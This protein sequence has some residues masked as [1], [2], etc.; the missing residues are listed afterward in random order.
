MAFVPGSDNVSQ[1]LYVNILAAELSEHIDGVW[2]YA[3]LSDSPI[4][5]TKSRKLQYGD[6]DRHHRL[7]AAANIVLHVTVLDCHPMV[8]LEANA[9]GRLSL[10]MNYKLG[11]LEDHAAEQLQS[12]DD[13]NDVN[14]LVERIDFVANIPFAERAQLAL[15]FAAAMTAEATARYKEFLDL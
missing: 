11:V 8:D 4:R 5:L 2:H 14:A 7:L 6:P 3:D 1:N 10:H 12:L 9:S 15:E 13:P